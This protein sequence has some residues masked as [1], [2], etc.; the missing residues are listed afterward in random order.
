MKMI[1]MKL[2]NVMFI[3]LL[4]AIINV[5]KT[6]EVVSCAVEPVYSTGLTKTWLMTSI[7]ESA[8]CAIVS[9]QMPIPNANPNPKTR[10]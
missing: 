7:S 10:P 8:E 6:W 1:M 9:N 5:K 4:Q 3:G 2:M